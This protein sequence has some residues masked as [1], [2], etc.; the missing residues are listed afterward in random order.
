MTKAQL[1]KAA[2]LL[3]VAD[4]AK[5]WREEFERDRQRFIEFSDV[6]GRPCV[7]GMGEGRGW[8]GNVILPRAVAIEMMAWLETQAR[9]RLKELGVS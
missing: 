6:T 9:R 1:R 4:N 5:L 2:D 8:D 7:D 3:Q